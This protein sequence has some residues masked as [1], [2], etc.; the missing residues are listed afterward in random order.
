VRLHREDPDDE[1]E[2]QHHHE[3]QAEVHVL[4]EV[5]HVCL[6]TVDDERSGL[7]D[8]ALDHEEG[9]QRD[10]AQHGHLTKESVDHELLR[11]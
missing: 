6:V 2:I 8:A 10:E 7:E 4:E 3:E 9:D 11:L 5:K 1:R